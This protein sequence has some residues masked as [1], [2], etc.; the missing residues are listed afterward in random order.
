[1]ADMTAFEEMCQNM[2]AQWP[3]MPEKDVKN[4]VSSAM[5]T[6][7][8]T[9]GQDSCEREDVTKGK[10]IDGSFAIYILTQRIHIKFICRQ[11]MM[12]QKPIR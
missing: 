6:G 9:L 10:L 4:I 12:T 7:I 8:Y 2:R 3:G 1:M 11:N 5:L